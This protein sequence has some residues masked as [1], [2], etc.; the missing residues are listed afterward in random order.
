MKRTLEALWNGEIAP[1]QTNGIHNPQMEELAVLIDR[2]RTAL[3][4]ELSLE[5]KELLQKYIDC[6]DEFLYLSA[7]EA[8]CD[9][10]RI[11]GKL[12]TEALSEE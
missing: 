9:G 11:A 1:G 8:F 10:F 12:L 3:E 7:A 4:R 2:N 6:T 5:Q